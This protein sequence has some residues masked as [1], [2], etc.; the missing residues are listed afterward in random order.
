VFEGGSI[1]PPR[2]STGVDVSGAGPSLELAFGGTPYEG[3]VV[4]GGIYGMS[5]PGPSYSANGVSLS[6]GSAVVSS[7]G[8]FADWYIDPRQGFHVQA[9]IGPAALTAAKGT[10]TEI[11]GTSYTFPSE[12]QAGNGISLLAGAGYEWWIGDQLSFG[13]LARIQYVSGSVKASG[14][15]TSTGVSVFMPALLGSI[16]YH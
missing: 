16:T 8:P 5:A 14:D 3:L 7:I 9:A 2:T 10:P 13:V 6:G 1:T 11:A 12:D 4:G 15:S